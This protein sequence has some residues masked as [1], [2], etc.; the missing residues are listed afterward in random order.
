VYK[1]CQIFGPP[2]KRCTATATGQIVSRKKAH[3]SHEIKTMGTPK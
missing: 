2:C 3:I 1:V